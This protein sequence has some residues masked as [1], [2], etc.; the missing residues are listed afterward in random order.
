[1]Q[2]FYRLAEGV[3]LS[4]ARMVASKACYKLVQDMN[5][6]AGITAI[7]TYKADCKH[8]KVPKEAA[9]NMRLTREQFLEV[10]SVSPFDL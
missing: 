8:E 4:E 2:D 1:M 9:R 3:L 7:I 5:Y 6:E 10:R